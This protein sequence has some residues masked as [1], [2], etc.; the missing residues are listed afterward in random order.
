MKWWIFPALLLLIGAS[1]PINSK[2]D[3]EKNVKEE[4]V[5]VYLTKQDKDFRMFT[6]TPHYQQLQ[7]RELALIGTSTSAVKQ[8]CVRFDTNVWLS[9]PLHKVSK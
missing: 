2:F 3:E 4:F 6:S 9:D 1:A 7:E 5:N 8:F